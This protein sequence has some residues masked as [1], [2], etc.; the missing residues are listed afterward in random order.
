MALRACQPAASPSTVYLAATTTRRRP[1]TKE[2]GAGEEAQRDRHLQTRHL[3]GGKTR[4]G[5]L[6]KSIGA[7]P[8]QGTPFFQSPLRSPDPGRH[9]RRLHHRL[10]THPAPAGPGH[11]PRPGGAHTLRPHRLLCGRSL[12]R[13]HNRVRLVTLL[14]LFLGFWQFRSAILL[15]AV[16]DA[17]VRRRQLAL[18]HQVTVWCARRVF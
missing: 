11:D 1:T 5:R 17:T 4:P 13:G 12:A 8:D 2:T 10:G 16:L 9:H 14:S 15:A 7:A 18:G 6:T 3:L